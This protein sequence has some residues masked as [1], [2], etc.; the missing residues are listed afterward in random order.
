MC[1]H[2]SMFVPNKAKKR[3]VFCTS[4]S[5]ESC[6]IHSEPSLGSASLGRMRVDK[7]IKSCGLHKMSPL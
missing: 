1:T 5:I 7:I 3:T 4:S 2:T 6:S